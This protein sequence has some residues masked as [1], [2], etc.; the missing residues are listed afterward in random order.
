MGH[1]WIGLNRL[2]TEGDHEWSDS[3]AFDFVNWAQGEPNDFMNQE[4]CV[5]AVDHVG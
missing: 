1:G 4:S 5:V 2:T 3:S